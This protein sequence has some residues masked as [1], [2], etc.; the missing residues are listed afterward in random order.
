MLEPTAT[1]AI[2]AVFGVLMTISAVMTRTL[3][4]LGVPI[5]L[6]FM[7]L[8]MVGGS[9]GVGGIAFNNADFAFR[10]GTVGLILILLDGG[11][12]TRWAA[13][14]TAAAP[15]GLLA[16][17][18]VAGTA[19]MVAVAGRLLGLSWGEAM[20]IGAIVSSTDAAAVFSVLR[21]GGI[22]MRPKLQATLEV[23]SCANDPMAVI[24][25]LA[26]I[27]ALETGSGLSPWLLL[28]IPLQLLIGTATGVAVG[29]SFRFLLNRV[30]L[31]TSGLYPVL[32]IASAFSAF[33]AST[34]MYGSGFLAVFI[35]SVILGNGHLPYVQGLRR[36]HDA[37]AW[38]AQVLMFLMLG[39]LV[40]P[41]KL[42]PMIGTGLALGLVLAFV[43]RPLAALV[44]LSLLGWKPR[45]SLFVGW[46]GL[47][48]A[49]PIILATFPIIT[50]LPNGERVFHLVFFV[51][52]VSAIIPGASIVPFTLW[53]RLGN[54]AKP[55]PSAALE[56]H[57]LKPLDRELH[58]Y[59]LDAN[60]PA[61]GKLIRD[62]ILPDSVAIVLIV[63]NDEP[64]PA[65]GSTTLQ[66]ND[67]LY[68]VGT[69]RELQQLQSLLH[70]SS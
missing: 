26:A 35:S 44:C 41:S 70:P 13:I 16:T 46:I 52:V 30:P 24:L 9:E 37:L 55:A 28:M 57:L 59:T 17:V 3:D 39:L 66:P 61:C 49:V 27:Q 50:G 45:E 2:I 63:R 51:V 60:A 1:A 20:L 53:S 43:A 58:D 64:L 10:V 33:G 36:V 69:K 29:L 65:R 32:T 68:I 54:R 18:G 12:N 67:L 4:R 31:S 8:G 42:V 23:E 62:I 5:V 34:L 56:L 6:L 21:G 15:A 7:V 22:R 11:L 38:M 48:G 25:T 14:R 47:R 19:G 40:F